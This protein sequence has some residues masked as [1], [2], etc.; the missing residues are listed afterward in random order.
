MPKTH[1]IEKGIHPANLK[2]INAE[3]SERQSGFWYIAEETAKKLVGGH[4]YL[5]YGHDKPSHFGGEILRYDVLT[6]ESGEL[7]GRVLFYLRASMEYK[8]VKTSKSDWG[9]EKKIVW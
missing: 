6:S 5:H 3:K 8:G 2:R 7:E 9:N 1:L 4:I